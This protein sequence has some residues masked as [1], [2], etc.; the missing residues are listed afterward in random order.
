MD[1]IQALEIFAKVVEY[2]GFSAAAWQMNTSPATLSKIIYKLEQSLGFKL[3]HRTTR[4]VNLT[5]QGKAFYPLAKEIL[6]KFNCA[7]ELKDQSTEPSGTIRIAIANIVA[8]YFL[9]DHLTTFL[10]QYPKISI[11][12]IQHA[13]SSLVNNNEADLAFTSYKLIDSK[14]NY[15]ALFSGCRQLIAAPQYIKTHGIPKSIFELTEHDCLVNT[16]LHPEGVWEFGSHKIHVNAR[17]KSS[18]PLQLIDAAVAGIGILWGMSFFVQD[19]LKTEKLQILPL[20][21]EKKQ[22][23]IYLCYPSLPK[24]DKTRLLIDFLLETF[25]KQHETATSS[26]KV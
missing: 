19:L 23:T 7:K 13:A 26:L 8:H 20:D 5:D 9:L 3:F 2:Q 12:L 14:L 24:N 18:D 15:E 6:H 4:Q 1:R 21:T 22:T 11:E 16:V 17:I 10:Q 25:K